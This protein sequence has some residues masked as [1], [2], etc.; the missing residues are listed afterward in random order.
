MNTLHRFSSILSLIGLLAFTPLAQAQTLSEREL[1][2][3][4]DEALGAQDPALAIAMASRAHAYHDQVSPTALE[5]AYQRLAQSPSP[6]L[7]A[8]AG[9]RLAGLELDANKPEEAAA[10]LDGLGFLTRFHLL[11][12]FPNP[13]MD[14][15]TQD[16]PPEQGIDVQKPVSEGLF[17]NLKWTPYK[18]IGH[19]AYVPFYT[20]ISPTH[21]AVGYALTVIESPSAT[22]AQL[23]MGADGAYVVWLNGELL[24]VQPADLGSIPDRERLE[25]RLRK[26]TNRLLIKV[27][28]RE[29]EMG[30]FARLTTPKGAPLVLPHSATPSPSDVPIAKLP[31][32]LSTVSI[33]PHHT[34]TRS[35]LTRPI[36]I[37]RWA[38]Y[39]SVARRLD[40]QRHHDTLMQEAVKLGAGDPQIAILAAQTLDEPWRRMAVIMRALEAHPQH[41]RLLAT[42]ATQLLDSQGFDRADEL[43]D[44]LTL[45]AELEPSSPSTRLLQARRM[46]SENLEHTALEILTS[47]ASEHGD[48]RGVQDALLRS[49]RGLSRT[50]L[51]REA[52]LALLDLRAHNDVE[53]RRYANH[54]AHLDRHDEALSVLDAGLALRPDSIHLML[55]RVDVLDSAKRHEDA[56]AQLR[57]I[58]AGIPTSS[59]LHER[60]GQWLLQHDQTRDAVASFYTALDLEPQNESLRQLVRY[61]DPEAESF[62]SPYIVEDLPPLNAPGDADYA[63]L[64]DQKIIRVLESGLSSTYH[65][66]VFEVLTEAG[67]SRLRYY[68]VYYTPDAELVEIDEARITRPDGSTIEVFS[69]DEFLVSDES[70]RMYYDYR[71]LVLGFPELQVGDKLE[72]RYRRSQTTQSNMF[73][74][75][76]GEVWYLQDI[77]PKAFTRLVVLA[78]SARKLHFRQPARVT[79][80][81]DTIPGEEQTAYL[82]SATDVPEIESEGQAPG[83][84]ELSAYAVIST[85]EDWGEVS[86]WYWNLIQ[87]Q[88]IVNNEIREVVAELIRDVDDRRKRVERIHNYVVKNTRYVALEFG[89]HGFK[90]YRTTVCFRRRFGDCKDKASLIK[91]MLE[92]AGIPANIVLV[93]TTMGGAIETQP[94]NLSIFDHAIAYVPELDLFLDG[95][96]E[97][98]GTR[99]LPS[100]DQ[101]VTVLIVKDGGDHE[102]RSTPVSE[103][104]DNRI[105]NRFRIDLSQGQDALIAGKV[106]A[107]GQFAPT[108][109]K[110]YESEEKRINLFA[111]ELASD[112]PGAAVTALDLANI[113]SLEEDVTVT[114][115]AQ[116]ANPLKSAGA[117]SGLLL[118]LG[119]KSDLTSRL[120]G[121]PSREQDLVLPY[122]F[123]VVNTIEYILPE[124]SRLSDPPE[125]VRLE[126]PFGLLELQAT[127]TDAGTLEIEALFELR[128]KRISRTDYPAFREYIL[129]VE[130]ALDAPLSL[131]SG[132][133]QP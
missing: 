102:L 70:I 100:M 82:I 8:F 106:T 55:G 121:A 111:S 19:N 83:F 56:H 114:F 97:F 77:V 73:D 91:V 58:L 25:L 6:A 78:P 2:T 62:E 17:P 80:A 51:E 96:A 9:W 14:G 127:M 119:H 126:S 49:A 133:T 92:E 120:A 12:P 7:S 34:W 20:T 42:R 16:F 40:P 132:G 87:D 103:P 122:P 15:L 107:T 98:S 128:S 10:R 31:D 81:F 21:D 27:A 67:A 88:L 4:V 59:D 113:E 123:S 54:L 131:V 18:S 35:K 48:I 53:R 69:Q 84:A 60:Y 43:D 95:T 124:N 109:R 41:P 23:L 11:G 39:L 5:A 118:P 115:E 22:R 89:V 28:N 37:A 52:M 125:P 50:S 57:D 108:Y 45:L 36:D 117:G 61:L 76:F 104:S 129:D 29:G 71:Q 38:Y 33:S 63:Y 75:Y 93:R 30:F 85:F 94:P 24:G 64:V 26:G 79:A 101:G 112:Y 90:P 44:T 47:L 116:I 72:I 68:P 65:Q 110:T 130:Q 99:E 13:G 66:V 74:T 3:L 32:D 105:Q 46:T 86:R 1:D